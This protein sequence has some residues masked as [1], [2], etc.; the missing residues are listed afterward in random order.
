MLP[1]DVT[2][3]EKGRM[4]WTAASLYTAAVHLTA[5]S[6][7]V[8]ILAVAIHRK[9]QLQ[10]QEEI[11]NVTAC[12]SSAI[13]IL[14]HIYVVLFLRSCVGSPS[15][16]WD[17]HTSKEEDEYNGYLIPKGSLIFGNIWA[18]NRDENVYSNPESFIPERFL[19][20]AMPEPASFGFGR[21]SCPGMHFAKASLFINITTILATFNIYP[22]LGQDG[23]EA[24]PVIKTL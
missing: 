18:I 12:Q 19:D 24:L 17:S 8:F 9:V 16:H 1:E 23:Q 7:Q 13:W 6:L 22:A 21:R 3:E 11:E 14:C 15:H 10:I 4:M 5:A 20:P 2:P